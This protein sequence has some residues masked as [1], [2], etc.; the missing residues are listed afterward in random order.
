MCTCGQPHSLCQRFVVLRVW[1]LSNFQGVCLFLSLRG[2]LQG[3]PQHRFDSVEC[4]CTLAATCLVSTRVMKCTGPCFCPCVPPGR[5]ILSAPLASAP[6]SQSAAEAPS[7]GSPCRA[8]T[9]AVC[10][11]CA[12]PLPALCSAVRAYQPSHVGGHSGFLCGCHRTG[13]QSVLGT[14]VC[15]CVWSPGVRW[16]SC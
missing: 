6:V 15:A 2:M 14:H 12:A 16:P 9:R 1:N 8:L 5:D 10:A 13:E 11:P 3:A 4:H 7:A